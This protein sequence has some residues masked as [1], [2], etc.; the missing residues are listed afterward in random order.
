M[1]GILVVLIALIIIHFCGKTYNSG[2]GC[3]IKN[4]SKTKRPN[5]HTAPQSPRRKNKNVK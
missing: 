3:N 5:V 4:K 2:G 1:E